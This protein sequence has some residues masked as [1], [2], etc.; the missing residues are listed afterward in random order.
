MLQRL[1]KFCVNSPIKSIFI[2]CCFVL[3]LGSGLTKLKV[4]FGYRTWFKETNPKLELFDAFERKFGSDERAIVVV[5][6]PD[7]VF[8]PKMMKTLIAI[9]DDLWQAK[10]VIRVD[11]ITNYQWVYSAGDDIFIEDLIT[12]STITSIN[13]LNKRKN[14][15]ISDKNVVNYLV[16]KQAD[17]ALI[18]VTIKPFINAVPNYKQIV[19]SIEAVLNKYIT[20]SNAEY[21]L[22]G[23]PTLSYSFEKSSQE[24]MRLFIPIVLILTL[25][26]VFIT[27]Q[28]LSA[29]VLSCLIVV[30]S[31]GASLAFAGWVNIPI[32]VITAI[33]PQYMIAISLSLVVHILVSFNTYLAKFSNPKQA[34]LVAVQ[35]NVLP[36][37]L[38]TIST[39]FGFLSFL[40]CDIPNITDMGI[41]AAGGTLSSWVL[42]FFILIPILS[43]IVTF[44][45]PKS[46]ESQ[47]DKK[48]DS[49][50]LA[51]NYTNWLDRHKK[52]II[53]AY[54]IITVLS[55][56]ALFK[57]KMNS[58][59]FDYFQDDFPL[60]IATNLVEEKIGGALSVEMVINSG[61][62]EGIK[63]PVFLNKVNQFQLWLES[64]DTVSKVVS[65]VDIVKK[66]NQVLHG[67]N[68]AY[69][70]IPNSVQDV[71]QQLFLYTMSLPQGL[72]LNDRISIENDA[73]RM[74]A[75][76]TLHDSKE[77]L[78]MI[79]VFEKKAKEMGLSMAV[80]GKGPLYQSNNQLFVSS[81]AKSM[82]LAMILISILMCIGLKSIKT[83]LFALIPNM[84]PIVLGASF[85]YILDVPL[86][87]GT[88]I[89]G[90]VC[91]GIA[92]DDTIHF[93]STY[94]L[95][96]SQNHSAKQATAKVLT[97][98]IP[99]LFTTTLI[100]VI[101]FAVFMF[102]SFIPNHNFGKFVAIILS[103]ALIIDLTLLPS[104]LLYFSK[105]KT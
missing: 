52:K 11:S 25:V 102:A 2:G 45:K 98:T 47:I 43:L 37:L 5:H 16:N 13:T 101:S 39:A 76:W 65:V 55:F 64:L 27:I 44:F 46:A 34:L 93:L 7:G 38:T 66:M 54:I 53:G 14:I 10:D 94:K 95:Y 86:D 73:I 85:L 12:E 21:H 51:I 83:G 30:L 35:K 20:Q 3:V 59:P 77:T 69:Y 104:M 23:L 89:V 105:D 15:A 75:M 88:V 29:V 100:L 18:Y 60:T 49:S 22:T 90:S 50:N 56:G 42:T 68:N 87:I 33:V 70:K 92:V 36:T 19:E 57:V 28:R 26:L 32:H 78:E 40:F 74:T 9:T 99:A 8:S 84:L 82:F 67:N 61:E 71:A 48:L 17:T 6:H 103:L 63:N 97:Y 58:N 80:T 96:L 24:D 41:M 72:D 4:D 79:D 81:F 91:L 31:V 1:A 62:K